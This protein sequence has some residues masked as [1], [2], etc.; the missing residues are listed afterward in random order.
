MERPPCHKV[1]DV[2]NESWQASAES[3]MPLPVREQQVV[4]VVLDEVTIAFVVL[5]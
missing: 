2:R 4:A 1:D 3:S 5:L